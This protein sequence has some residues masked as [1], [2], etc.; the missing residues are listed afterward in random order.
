MNAEVEVDELR[1]A[2]PPKTDAK[3]DPPRDELEPPGPDAELE[4]EPGPDAAPERE[5]KAGV[6]E[7]AFK[8]DPRNEIYAKHRDVRASEQQLFQTDEEREAE[9]LANAPEKV[10]IKVRG[11]ELEVDRAEIERAGIATLQKERAADETLAD[12]SRRA[13]AVTEGERRL[14]L[15][16]EN[17]RKGLDAK[18]QPIVSQPPAKGVADRSTE[19]QTRAVKETASAFLKAVYDGDREAGETALL[20]YGE[21]LRAATQVPDAAGIVKSVKD[22]VLHDLSESARETESRAAAEA[23]ERDRVEANRIFREEFQNVA[24]DTDLL[25]MAQGLATRLAADQEWADK[26]RAAIAREVG[27]RVKARLTTPLQAE[28]DTR[29]HA[30]QGKSRP[31]AAGRQPAEAPPAVPNN[32]Q[33]IRQL[34][35]NSGSNSAPRR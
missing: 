11:Q 2:L 1:D 17:L 7:P 27:K 32:R 13:A 15:I 29:R 25:A 31:A 23:A 33:Y 28:L 24:D 10:K 26:G 4:V 18:G 35:V 6:S 30:K 34:Q 12:A 16:E 5:K 14:A 9:R 8:T 20:S 22:A 19:E 21:A 3:D